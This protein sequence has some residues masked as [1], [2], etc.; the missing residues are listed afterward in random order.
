MSEVELPEQQMSSLEDF[1]VSFCFSPTALLGAAALLLCFHLV[2]NKFTS[3]EFRKLPPGPRPLP[4]LGNLLQ[5]DLNKLD[6]SLWEVRSY[7]K[8]L[9]LVIYLSIYPSIYLSIYYIFIYL[10]IYLSIYYLFIY[11]SIHLSIY[12]SIYPFLYYSLCITALKETWFCIHGLLW[13]Q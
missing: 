5:L 13:D 12:P 6:I 3:Q 11:L 8:Q 2:S 4:L 10:S 9:H 7:S 1:V